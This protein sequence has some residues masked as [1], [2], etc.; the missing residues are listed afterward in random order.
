MLFERLCS[1]FCRASNER[2]IN[3]AQ[4]PI[5]YHSRRCLH[6]L[7]QNTMQAPYEQ[8]DLLERLIFTALLY[9]RE[10]FLVG[11]AS[12][13]G[14]LVKQTRSQSGLSSDIIPPALWT[15]HVDVAVLLAQIVPGATSN[16]AAIYD[17]LAQA[18]G[19]DHGLRREKSIASRYEEAFES[20]R[21]RKYSESP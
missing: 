17:V 4:L 19:P 10:W 6:L 15:R 11:L 1:V 16:L 5:V 13:L 2:P 20:F 3:L 14:L 8:V 18:Q 12:W 9:N 21:K 7:L